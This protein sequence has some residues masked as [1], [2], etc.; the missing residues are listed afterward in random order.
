LRFSVVIPTLRRNAILRKTLDD[1]AR[2]EPPPDE[3]I[4]VDADAA[5]SSRAVVAELEAREDRISFRYAE[6]PASLTLQRNRGIDVASGEIVLFLDDDVAIPRD[7]FAQLLRAYEDPSTVGATGRVIEPATKRVGGVGS[8]VR[9]WLPGG[10]AEGEFTRYGYPRYVR[11]TEQARDVEYMLGCFMSARR[12][13][14]ARVRFDEAL[15]GYALAEDED[16]SYR[17]SR[18]GRIRYL[19]ELVVQHE[20]FGFASKDPRAFNRLVVGN[21][22][23]LFRKNFARTRVAKA[24]FALFVLM[25][26]THRLVNREWRAA[27]GLLEGVA[28]VRRGRRGG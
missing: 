11:H 3:V 1:L 24:Q 28:E 6:S 19:P 12:E 15:G 20:K 25:L 7:A 21:R 27:Q 13:A 26:L 17:L 16:F 14:A 9:D 4:V 18:L 8:L 10:G 2:C 22:A 23:Y 5:H